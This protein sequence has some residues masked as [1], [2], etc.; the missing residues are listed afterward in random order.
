MSSHTAS[1]LVT[2]RLHVGRLDISDLDDLHELQSSDNVM[3]Y[4]SGQPLAY[5]Q[6][7]EQLHQVLQHYSETGNTFRVWSVRRI[8]DN[9]FV[10]TCALVGRSPCEDEIGYRFKEQYWGQ[11]YGTELVSE[12]VRYWLRTSSIEELFALVY[13][14]NAA[15]WRILEREGFS[16]VSEYVGENGILDRRYRLPRNAVDRASI[17]AKVGAI[18]L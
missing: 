14:A 17:R 5:E 1:I 8:I 9:A 16:L 10:G 3:R 7:G 2:S 11:G 4:C 6:T 18:P 15:S 13:T 12:L